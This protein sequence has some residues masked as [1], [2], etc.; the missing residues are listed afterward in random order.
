MSLAAFSIMTRW[1]RTSPPSRVPDSTRGSRWFMHNEDLDDDL[2]MIPDNFNDHWDHN[3]EFDNEPQCRTACKA[4]GKRP[5]TDS[6]MSTLG[7]WVVATQWTSMS[8]Q[9]LKSERGEVYIFPEEEDESELVPLASMKVS[10]EAFQWLNPPAKIYICEREDVT[11]ASERLDAW[12]AGNLWQYEPCVDDVTGLIVGAECNAQIILSGVTVMVMARVKPISINC[13]MFVNP[14]A[15]NSV[16]T[17]QIHSWWYEEISRID[18]AQRNSD[19]PHAYISVVDESSHNCFH[20][21][22]CASGSHKDCL[23]PCWDA[24]PLQ[25]LNQLYSRI[26]NLVSYGDP[27]N[28]SLAIGQGQIYMP[29][30][31]SWGKVK[32][33]F[34]FDYC[35]DD[36]F[37]SRS[38]SLQ[39][40]KLWIL[41]TG[42]TSM[43]YNK[44]KLK[45]DHRLIRSTQHSLPAPQLPSTI[46]CQPGKQ[47]RSESRQSFIKEVVHNV[48]AIQETL[49][50]RLMMHEQM[51]F[52]I[53]LRISVL[54]CQK[55]K[56]KEWTISTA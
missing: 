47:M 45:I 41:F 20:H 3:S 53:L 1:C 5:S 36:Q 40:R 51:Y 46:V 28:S 50:T 34:F 25:D 38:V 2:S 43:A 21:W 11:Q 10:N 8:V 31:H 26:S 13:A 32:V 33:L 15:T 27:Q 29:H 35:L 19:P 9:P 7:K 54:S 24:I 4:I 23:L 42:H 30:K 39:W 12:K 55:L 48:S 56:L 52:A 14:F 49:I 37:R 16:K 6:F 22:H 17:T 44:W 18:T